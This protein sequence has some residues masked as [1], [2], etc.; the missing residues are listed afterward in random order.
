MLKKYAECYH[1]WHKKETKEIFF[2]NFEQ[3]FIQGGKG[4]YEPWS[5]YSHFEKLQERK[6]FEEEIF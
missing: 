6:V 3:V 1:N 4:L 2:V 5:N